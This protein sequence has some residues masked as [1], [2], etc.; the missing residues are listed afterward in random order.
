MIKDK[1]N[2]PASSKYASYKRPPVRGYANS[3]DARVSILEAESYGKM[4]IPASNKYNGKKDMATISRLRN[5]PKANDKP[6]TT[7][8]K[9]ADRMSI[10]TL[11]TP[12][13]GA[14][15]DDRKLDANRM[16]STAI[17]FN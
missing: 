11:K 10:P 5:I 9:K 4:F 15:L 13:P 8:T 7:G 17:K 16:R 3:K 2:I 14:N 12:A 1:K 6:D